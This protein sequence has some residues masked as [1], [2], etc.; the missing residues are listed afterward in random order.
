MA[1]YATC[2]QRALGRWVRSSLDKGR[3]ANAPSI[4]QPASEAPDGQGSAKAGAVPVHTPFADVPA[5]EPSPG[6]RAALTPSAAPEDREQP[7]PSEGHAHA[8]IS[9]GSQ[10]EQC[11]SAP[12]HGSK[13]G[14][15]R[16]TQSVGQEHSSGSS[17]P[18]K[19]SAMSSTQSTGDHLSAAMT[20]LVFPEDTLG[21]F[22][23]PQYAPRSSHL[24][25][26]G[27]L[28]PLS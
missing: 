19:T 26:V 14:V 16:Q 24:H 21:G 8:G 7:A 28:S 15:G 18:P 1:D 13:A 5:S 9:A 12:L 17:L 11:V 4:E 27:G 10:E 23:G 25:E 2:V 20:I 22:P 3:A 6:R